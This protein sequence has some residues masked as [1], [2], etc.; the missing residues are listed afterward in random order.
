MKDEALYVVGRYEVRRIRQRWVVVDRRTGDMPCAFTSLA[1]ARVWAER[2]AA[3]AA[4]LEPE[5]AG[6]VRDVGRVPCP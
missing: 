3:I 6:A 5:D 4:E 1:T 2:L